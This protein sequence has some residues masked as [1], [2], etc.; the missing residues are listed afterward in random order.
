MLTALIQDYRIRETPS[1]TSL[2]RGMELGG[3]IEKERGEEIKS[4]VENRE[5][6]GKVSLFKENMGVRRQGI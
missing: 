4:K 5:E 6:M 1:A 2:W 3:G